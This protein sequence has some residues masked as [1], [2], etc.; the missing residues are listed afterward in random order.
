[1][2]HNCIID[3]NNFKDEAI[4]PKR[5]ESLDMVYSLQEHMMRSVSNEFDKRLEQ[6]VVENLNKIGYVFE[7]NTAFYDFLKERM[8]RLGFDDKPHYYEFYI[9]FVDEKN[10]GTFV[11]SYSDN[12]SLYQRDDPGSFQAKYIIQFGQ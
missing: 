2:D 8:F 5:V 12:V 7:D 1:M 4:Y 10:R 3:I 6:Y 11:G 9:D